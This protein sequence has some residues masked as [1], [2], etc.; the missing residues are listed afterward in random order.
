MNEG[1]RQANED[2]FRQSVTN[3]LDRIID[4]LEG[5][6]NCKCADPLPVNLNRCCR[7]EKTIKR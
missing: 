1:A 2:M 5:E 4:L 3:R 7:C 6:K